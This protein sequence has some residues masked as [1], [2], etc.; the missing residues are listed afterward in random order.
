MYCQKCGWKAENEAARYCQKCGSM[1]QEEVEATESPLQNRDVEITSRESKSNQKQSSLIWP[2][3]APVV[4]LVL[5]S[6]IGYYYYSS[7]INKNEQVQFLQ[8]KAEKAALT[9]DYE[10]ALENLEKAAEIRPSYVLLAELEALI[11]KAMEFEDS[12]AN[13]DDL[14]KNQKLSEA[15]TEIAS[16]K[17]LLNKQ[18]GPLFSGFSDRVAE[19]ESH[20]SIAK[21]KVDIDRLNTVEQLGA[22][23]QSLSSVNHEE[24]EEVARLIKDKIVA[25]TINEAQ[26]QMN[27]KEFGNAI[28]LIK[29]ALHYANGDE[30]LL[31]FNDRIVQEQAAFEEA[32]R[33]RIEQAMV[34]AA[35]E[36]LKN[37]TAAVSVE[38]LEASLDEYGDLQI[39]G[40]VKNTATVPISAIELYYTIYNSEGVEIGQDM[41]YVDP[42]YLEPGEVG[43]FYGL[44]FSVYEDV[45]VQI[46]KAMW[47]LN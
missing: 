9:G 45:T 5:A 21:I 19:K 15:E 11:S 8:E 4:S 40:E 13:I 24:K 14:L 37:K 33:N 3:A 39:S 17:E 41:T 32:E 7:Q 30:K 6:G 25:I 29:E 26:L 31:A 23:L 22:K 27:N 36:D 16:L 1:L 20:L 12:F 35:Q 46:T 34:A 47:H 38:S 43:T 42:Y 28:E 2:I 44:Y 10:A 18:E